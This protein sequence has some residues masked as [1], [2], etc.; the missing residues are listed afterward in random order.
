[1]APDIFSEF[2]Y[3]PEEVA[4]ILMGII[5]GLLVFVAVYLLGILAYY[6]MTSIAFC[7]IGRRRGVKQ[8]WLVWIPIARNYAIGA[9]ADECDA[10]SGI[11][12]RFRVILLVLMLLYYAFEVIMQGGMRKAVE[13]FASPDFIEAM[14][15][16]D[17]ETFLPMLLK[18]FGALYAGIMAAALLS[19][20]YWVLY[21]VCIYKIFESLSPRFCVLHIVLSVIIPLY[22]PICLLCLKNKGYPYPEEA[23]ALPEASGWYEV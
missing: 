9:L 10:R 23:P 14:E 5:I 16:A 6:I 13:A 21:L 17:I 3:M 11:K 1:M 7:R 15:Y 18:M 22:M 12:R 2:S 19:I 8:P 4:N 20:V